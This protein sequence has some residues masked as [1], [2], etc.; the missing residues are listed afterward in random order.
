MIITTKDE[1][2]DERTIEK[3]VKRATHSK[4]IKGPQN[5]QFRRLGASF[6][7]NGE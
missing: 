5:A 4:A 3:K 1:E 2:A 6:P 7:P